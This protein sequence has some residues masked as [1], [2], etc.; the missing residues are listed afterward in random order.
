MMQF[1]DESGSSNYCFCIALVSC[2]VMYPFMIKRY[3]YTFLVN[4]NVCSNHSV[5]QCVFMTRFSYI[6]NSVPYDNHMDAH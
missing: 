3:A 6:R 1:V 4:K 5:H 2:T